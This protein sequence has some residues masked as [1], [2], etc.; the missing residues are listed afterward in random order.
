MKQ[1]FFVLA[2][3]SQLMLRI[4]TMCVALLILSCLLGCG[5]KTAQQKLTGRWK[6]A[7]DVTNEV[8]KYADQ[9]KQ[10]TNDAEAAETAKN[11]AEFTGKFASRM[12]LGV[13]LD[14]NDDGTAAMR[15]E[16]RVFGLKGTPK[17]K[18]EVVSPKDPVKMRL[19]FGDQQYEGNIVFRDEDAFFFQFE[20]PLEAATSFMGDAPKLPEDAKTKPATVL[21]RRWEF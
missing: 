2:E 4:L 6:G 12:A 16:T 10:K 13:E 5:L 7:P 11:I 14:L 18:W 3:W 1:T 15:G 20:A 21:F 9:V 17:G 8:Q 19:T